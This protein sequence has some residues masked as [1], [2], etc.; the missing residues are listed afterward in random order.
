M[1][2]GQGKD[3]RGVTVIRQVAGAHLAYRF[4]PCTPHV[5]GDENHSSF[6]LAMITSID[7][8]EYLWDAYIQS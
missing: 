4:I 3:A 2:G 8:P 6:F 7:P 1:Q 5:K